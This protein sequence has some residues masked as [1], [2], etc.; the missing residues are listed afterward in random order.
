MLIYL[1][2]FIESFCA[3]LTGV[4]LMLYLKFILGFSEISAG[5]FLTISGIVSAAMIFLLGPA[6]DK[7]GIKKSAI[8]GTGALILSRIGLG[9]SNNA[10]LAMILYFIAMAGSAIKVS[11]ITVFLKQYKKSFK[12]DYLI[13]N[14]GYVVAGV[15]FDL[16]KNYQ[17]VYLLAGLASIINLYWFHKLEVAP[18]E[19]KPLKPI[20]W[21]MLRMVLTY[22]S[23]LLAVSLIFTW[24]NS[25]LPK[26]V[27]Q[28]LGPDAPVGKICSSLNPLIIMITIPLV[29]LINKY[30][31]LTVYKLLI[32]GSTLSAA[33][34]FLI[35]LPI[36]YLYALILTTIV[37]TIGE[38]IWSPSNM[39]IAAKICPE[40]EEGRYM[41]ISLIPRTIGGMLMGSFIAFNM[42]HF[43]YSPVPHYNMP[44]ILLGFM[45]AIT[46]LGLLI[47][48]KNFQNLE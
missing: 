39:E 11:S 27:L 7:Y 13:F 4:N 12:L 32:L 29:A 20:D 46:P 40:G 31:R 42:T 35:G 47:F 1:I 41:T 8:V 38:S 9:L 44:F 21:K 3:G 17:T 24:F 14:M 37:F 28:V 6:V 36:G 33:S 48:K 34:M 5:W 18:K 43:V 45:A 23:I 26:W 22:N 19:V 15:V 2:S 10:V 30:T 25:G 16:F